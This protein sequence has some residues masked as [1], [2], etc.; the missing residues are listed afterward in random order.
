MSNNMV[1]LAIFNNEASADTAAT[2]LKESGMAKKDAIGVLVLNDEGE[3][4]TEKIGKR[5]I[6]KGVGIGA[7]VA[8]VTP[9]GLA[10]GL[11]GGG[12]VGA[13]HHKNLGLSKADRER[14][15]E[16]LQGGKAAVGVL[17]P[18]EEA[19]IVKDKLTEL[20]GAAESHPVSDEAL[21]EAQ[22]AAQN[23]GNAG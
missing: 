14:I 21:Q 15:G 1:V 13:L 23:S 3:L 12:L 6:S 10:A 18:V 16:E 7:A 20:G 22:T 5:S 8:L 19:A 9:V 17:A 11:L 2:S 4:K